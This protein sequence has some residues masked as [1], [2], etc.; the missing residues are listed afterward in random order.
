MPR[1]TN[2]RLFNAHPIDCTD[3]SIKKKTDSE[4][5]SKFS[6]TVAGEPTII[7]S[8]IKKDLHAGKPIDRFR[9]C[10]CRMS[11]QELYEN[12]S[13]G[14]QRHETNVL[15][16]DPRIEYGTNY[17][18]EIR[19]VPNQFLSI[20]ELCLRHANGTWYERPDWILYSE[21]EM[22]EYMKRYGK[23][24]YAKLI[25]ALTQPFPLSFNQKY[26]IIDWGCGQALA[27]MSFIEKYGN[28][29]VNSITLI[30]P[31]KIVIKRAAL[32]CRKFASK[33]QI[34]TICKNLD[35][36]T[37]NDFNLTCNTRIHLLSNILDILDI[38][39]VEELTHLVDILLTDKNYFVCV[40]PYIYPDKTENLE[41]FMN[42]FQC[43][44]SFTKYHDIESTKQG[45]FWACNN[46]FGHAYVSHGNRYGC[47]E[48]YDEEYGCEHKWTRVIKVFS[49]G[50]NFV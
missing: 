14:A 44:G 34:Y 20:R 33:A 6:C 9:L 21:D 19:D 28:E 39:Q 23:M 42:H 46:S 50:Q 1:I 38:Y 47:C 25:S 16:Y 12:G 31:S 35:N 3:V 36:I 10:V 11:Y 2:E 32:H 18:H 13:V 43:R 30:E 27:T 26:D 7:D 45:R 4:G 24:H 37:Q 17:S 5:N 8:H 22:F 29:Y 40:S 15:F 49:C 48:F 41:W